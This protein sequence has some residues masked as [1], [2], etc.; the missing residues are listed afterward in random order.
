MVATIAAG[1]TA[2]YYT[3]QTEYYL[4]GREPAGRWISR[5]GDFGV[6]DGTEVE[7][8]LFERLHAGVD[9]DGETLLSNTGD[10]A[11]RVAGYDLTLSAPKSVSIIYALAGDDLRKQ[12]D[13]AQQRAA[14]ATI[15]L[16]DR[17]AAFCRRG[18]KGVRLEPTSLTVACFQHSEARP[19][20]HVDGKVFADPQCHLHNVILNC[21]R[22][23]SD[24]TVGA[25]DGRFLF[26]W[27]MAAGAAYHVA[28]S[29]ELQ[30]LGFSIGEIGKNGVFQVIGIPAE[31]QKYFSARRREVGDSIAREGLTTEEAPALAAAIALSSRS[32]KVE[33]EGANRFEL[34]ATEAR[35]FGIDSERFVE[36]LRVGQQLT[37][38]ERDNIIAKRLGAAPLQLIEHES[39]FEK[40][41]LYAAVGTAL[42]GTGAGA[43]RVETEV[44][45]LLGRGKVVELGRNDLDQPIYST[46]EQ[47]ALE[48]SLLKLAQRLSRRHQL[49][50]DPDLVRG[51]CSARGVNAEQTGAAMAASRPVGIV[52]AEGAAGS[53]KTTTLGPVVD[54]YKKVGARIIGT[55][56]AWRIAHQLRDDLGIETKATDAWIA[57]A[58]AGGR[59]LD[60][61]TVLLVDEAG[62]LSS[63]QMHALLSE[64]D[65]AGAKVILLGDRRQLPSIGA[66]PGFQIVASVVEASRVDTIVR[67]HEAWAREAIM[68]IA[69]GR[70]ADGLQAFD[71]RGLLKACD[72]PKAAI[73]SLVDAWQAARDESMGVSTLLIAKTNAQVRAINSEVRV[74][75]QAEGR[76]DAGEIEIAAVSP[77]GHGYRLPLAKGDDIR[78]LMRHDRLGVINGTVATVEQIKGGAD[79]QI[80]A[81]IANRQF[82]FRVSDLADEHGRARL[83]H[84]YA[85]TVYGSQGLTTDQTF[86]LL[87][88]SMNRHDLYVAASRARNR[89]ELYFDKRGVDSQFRSELPLAQRRDATI[90]DDGRFEWLARR[91][92]RIQIKSCTLDPTLAVAEQSLSRSRER[93]WELDRG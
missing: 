49:T 23:A 45:G 75:L 19:A 90:S 30:A 79:P 54:A 11:E 25:L 15:A 65:R 67:Q 26:Q 56:Q 62:L 7:S 64:V 32:A 81:R 2:G 29:A 84:A 36:N 17:H 48:R 63:R 33:G 68:E 31:A 28:L 41:H 72:S 27:K 5:S 82:R 20:E 69:K 88:P 38:V 8:E 89:T 73:Q 39:V 16:L 74:R 21:A 86:V 92:S 58:A 43:E 71:E 78:F 4:G 60:R 47:I 76:L 24:G 10:V 59:F 35:R 80:K 6:V 55:A 12:I 57:T 77:S 91:L 70:V 13:E 34:W 42:V 51:L 53:G 40:R 1:T 50:P 3:K 87:D 22:R 66:G 44:R 14:R 85:S 9:I 37:A 18:R 52:I 46:P 61:N 83:G 93:S